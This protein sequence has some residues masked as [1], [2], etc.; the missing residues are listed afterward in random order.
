M[1]IVGDQPNA[2]RTLWRRARENALDKEFVV[3]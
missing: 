1:A 2:R 3:E